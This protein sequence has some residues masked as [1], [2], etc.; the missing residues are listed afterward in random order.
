MGEIEGH[1]LYHELR[2]ALAGE[3][4]ALCAL[5]QRGL[6]RYLDALAHEGVGD[7][8]LRAEI[9]AARG[10][11]AA[12]GQMLRAARDALGAA[13]LQRDV[14]E[15]LRRDLSGVQPQLG[16]LEGRLR[17]AM[18]RSSPAMLRPP[19]PCTACEQ[20]ADIEGAYLSGLLG[21]IG[22]G[23][24]LDALGESAGLCVPHLRAA[25]QRAPDV[26]T[27]ERLRA[28]QL[29]VWQRLAGELDEFI[30]KQDYRFTI[31]PI[32]PEADS[33]VRAIALISGR[34]GLA[35]HVEPER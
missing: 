27:F 2:D 6:R 32:G 34:P 21:G 12:H 3:A 20:L 10:F 35:A 33:W 9:R 23:T 19:R 28:A 26:Q 11:C 8:R 30:R 16:S 25:L 1:S 31:E 18:R 4:C 29:L 22:T 14:L 5:T 24:L 15:S 17:R 7:E 13:I